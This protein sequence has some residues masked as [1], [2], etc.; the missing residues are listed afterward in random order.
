MDIPQH[1]LE[2]LE[3]LHARKK[4]A[5]EDYQV[6]RAVILERYRRGDSPEPGSLELRVRDAEYRSFS[7]A[8]LVRILGEEEAASL[9]SRLIPTRWTTVR[10][11]RRAE[12]GPCSARSRE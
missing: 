8:E 9:K 1:Q 12:Q 3:R 6:L 7:E 10:V 2:E 4:Q 11:I 5:D